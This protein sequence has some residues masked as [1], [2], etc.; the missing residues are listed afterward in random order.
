[1][2]P[3]CI[4]ETE[5]PLFEKSHNVWNLF[6]ERSGDGRKIMEVLQEKILRENCLLLISIFGLHLCPVHCCFVG[7]V[8]PYFKDFS[9]Y[10]IIA[11][12]FIMYL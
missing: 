9:A 7:T 3:Q 6:M 10:G 2:Q 8:S 5:W 12:T 4:L 1:M 11:L